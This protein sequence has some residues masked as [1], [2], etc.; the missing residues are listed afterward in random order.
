MR[1]PP[2]DGA[3]ITVLASPIGDQATAVG[4]A[5]VLDQYEGSNY[6]RTDQTCPSLTPDIDGEPIYVVYLGPFAV[7]S[8][9]CSAR[10][11][12]PEGAYARVLSD[13]LGPDHSV[14]CA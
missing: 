4:V 5:A 13:E 1:Q 11:S 12:G 6:L 9:A 2:C 10:S 3:Y 14:D 7:A 8:D